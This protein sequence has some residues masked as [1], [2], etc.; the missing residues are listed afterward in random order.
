MREIIR[1]KFDLDKTQLA[2]L[3]GDQRDV[4]QHYVFLCLRNARRQPRQILAS[5]RRVMR[6]YA[7]F[8]RAVPGAV[9]GVPGYKRRMKLE[10]A[11]EGAAA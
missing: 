2:A 11:A 4:F 6:E 7:D 8:W 9:A 3:S 1:N 10:H 5:L